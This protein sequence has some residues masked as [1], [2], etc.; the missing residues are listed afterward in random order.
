MLY[1]QLLLIHQGEIV[2]N[3]AI[4]GEMENMLYNN[5]ESFSLYHIFSILSVRKL[6]KKRFSRWTRVSVRI[7][8]YTI[9]KVLCINQR[10]SLKLHWLEFPSHVPHI[11][12][13]G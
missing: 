8:E 7:F 9:C 10:L 12:C 3:T 1:I 6:F 11:C 2:R 4:K 5:D 13:Y